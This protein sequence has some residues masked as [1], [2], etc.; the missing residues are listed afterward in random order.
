MEEQAEW[1]PG[2]E[3]V[4]RTLLAIEPPS[5]VLETSNQPTTLP[6]RWNK[7]AQ[8]AF[9]PSTPGTAPRHSTPTAARHG[10][11]PP[12][13]GLRGGFAR[14]GVR[15]R[16]L[17]RG[18]G[19]GRLGGLP[20]I[21]WEEGECEPPGKLAAAAQVDHELTGGEGAR[22]PKQGEHLGFEW[23]HNLPGG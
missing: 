2:I 10:K 1:I 6:S 12:P 20:R 17:G 13:P 8:P 14:R 15:R 21:P 7:S 22:G 3:N 11:A 9:N 19:R 5:N 16:C 23:P 4:G 18:R